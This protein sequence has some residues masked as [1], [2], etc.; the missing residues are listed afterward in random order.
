MLQISG[1]E[2]KI[3]Q[4]HSPNTKLGSPLIPTLQIAPYWDDEVKYN[5]FV[6]IKKR[7]KLGFIS[8]DFGVHPVSSLIRGKGLKYMNKTF[9]VIK[10]Y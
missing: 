6:L 9:G 10:L 1:Q 7:I 3:M 5:K 2:T 8:S 4:M